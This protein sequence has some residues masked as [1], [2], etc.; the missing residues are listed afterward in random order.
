M[1]V[2]TSTSAVG[3]TAAWVG[4]DGHGTCRPRRSL[5]PAVPA[6][7][8]AGPAAFCSIR[9]FHDRLNRRHGGIG[10]WILWGYILMPRG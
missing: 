7:A 3:H 8:E 2:S 9:N 10:P 1:A 5:Q 4:G 6:R